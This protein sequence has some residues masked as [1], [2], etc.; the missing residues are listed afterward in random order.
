MPITQRVF[1]QL[2]SGQE[3]VL[4]TLSNGSGIEIDITTYGGVSFVSHV[5]TL[6]PSPPCAFPTR[7]G[8]STTLFLGLILSKTMRKRIRHILALFAAVLQIGS[9]KVMVEIVG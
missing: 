2:S 3:A 4:F 6:R 1:G 8:K 9:R 5:L 7:V